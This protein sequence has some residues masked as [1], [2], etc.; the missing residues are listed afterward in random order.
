[1]WGARGNVPE[2]ASR[3]VTTTANGDHEMGVEVLED[4][5]CGGLAQLVDLFYD[6]LEEVQKVRRRSGEIVDKTQSACL[7]GVR[8]SRNNVFD[9]D[10]HGDSDSSQVL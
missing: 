1:M 9:T 10:V 6:L 4:F 7:R 8:R 3:N 2:D 5:L